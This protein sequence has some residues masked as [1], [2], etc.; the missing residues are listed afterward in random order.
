MKTEPTDDVCESL[1]RLFPR[2]VSLARKRCLGFRKLKHAR[3]PL[4]LPALVKSFCLRVG[5]DGRQGKGEQLKLILRPK[6][7]AAS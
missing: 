2:R 3:Y 1:T 4:R 7:I 6:L 5:V